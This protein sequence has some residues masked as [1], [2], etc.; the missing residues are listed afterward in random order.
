MLASLNDNHK[1]LSWSA[2]FRVEMIKVVYSEYS[3]DS[4]A[5]LMRA[6]IWRISHVL[7]QFKVT[8]ALVAWSPQL[9]MW[10]DQGRDEF[11]LDSHGYTLKFSRS[12]SADVDVG[13]L[14]LVMSISVST[15][16]SSQ[17]A[18]PYC[19]IESGP[20]PSRC[21]PVCRSSVG[22]PV[23]VPSELT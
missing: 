4:C 23:A 6:F 19:A 9:L 7:Y 11:A 16:Q 5:L 3:A 12:L 2:I 22:C 13:D 17:G 20:G 1:C 18:H 10:C 15:M 8:D 14:Y 21:P